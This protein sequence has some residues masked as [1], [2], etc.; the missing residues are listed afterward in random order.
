MG[1]TSYWDWKATKVTA[2]EVGVI[3]IMAQRFQDLTGHKLEFAVEQDAIIINGDSSK[4]HDHETLLIPTTKMTKHWDFCKTAHK[5]YD[6]YVCAVL[7]Y[8]AKKNRL[9]FSSDGDI[10]AW[11]GDSVGYEGNDP[12]NRL[13]RLA[14]IMNF[15]TKNE[16][17]SI[18]TKN[19][20]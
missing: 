4:D 13:D 11:L 19:L 3:K 6:L 16:I 12:H 8:L 7:I 18:V 2:A 9:T 14:L 10:D 5:P 1:Y 17:K 15:L 20:N